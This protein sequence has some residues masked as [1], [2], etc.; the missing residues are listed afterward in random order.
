L[1][2]WGGFQ[3]AALQKK[4]KR[5][6]DAG[7]IRRSHRCAQNHRQI[8]AAPASFPRIAK[9]AFRLRW[10]EAQLKLFVK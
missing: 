9:Q 3:P 8:G 4:I 6:G 10:N 2:L 1:D 5:E 7:L